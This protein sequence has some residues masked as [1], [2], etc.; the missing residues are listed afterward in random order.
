MSYT[1][2]PSLESE[3]NLDKRGNPSRKASD[4]R[5][6]LRKELSSLIDNLRGGH[7]KLLSEP[8]APGTRAISSGESGSGMPGRPLV[9]T[10]QK[11]DRKRNKAGQRALD[12]SEGPGKPPPSRNVK[13]SKNKQTSQS[14]EQREKI[15]QPSS[16]QENTASSAQQSSDIFGIG[17]SKNSSDWGGLFMW[18]SQ[19][20]RLALIAFIILVIQFLFYFW[21][22]GIPAQLQMAELAETRRDAAQAD[23]TAA[24]RRRD[25]VE[26]SVRALVSEQRSLEAEVDR[27][28]NRRSDLLGEIAALQAEMSLHNDAREDMNNTSLQR[29]KTET[30]AKEEILQQQIQKLQARANRAN[31][32]DTEAL[33]TR[34][35]QVQALEARNLALDSQLTQLQEQLQNV[36]NIS[37]GGSEQDL[38]QFIADRFIEKVTIIATQA[39]LII[40]YGEAVVQLAREYEGRNLPMPSEVLQKYFTQRDTVRRLIDSTPTG[41]QIVESQ[42]LNREF[43]LLPQNIA[44]GMR[45]Q[46]R[47]YL[48]ENSQIFNAPLGVRLGEYVNSAALRQ[49]L[50]ESDG[51]YRNLLQNLQNLRSV[52]QRK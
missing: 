21:L 47:R 32:A 7:S 10:Y 34:T 1:D 12:L 33:K 4:H 35:A 6:T 31:P 26:A 25:I 28:R 46:V 43:A 45:D 8:T 48:N 38:Q 50:F 17:N 24:I 51:N 18:F 27:L 11:L 40:D 19:P 22:E 15:W 39:R 52:L 36:I 3:P 9:K 20:K 44:E 16:S 37:T 13:S 2:D 49:Q 5:P 42:L 14:K 30:Q 41:R 29:L 23:R